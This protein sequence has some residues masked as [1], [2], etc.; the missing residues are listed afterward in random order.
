MVCVET[1]EFACKLHCV[2]T[3]HK[4]EKI[5]VPDSATEIDQPTCNLAAAGEI[6][7]DETAAIYV[8]GVEPRTVRDWRTRRGLP[9]IRITAKCVRIRKSDLDRWLAQ[10]LVAITRGAF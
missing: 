6:F 1:K 8:G 10:H 4:E 9:F 5:L 2:R 3:T 7:T